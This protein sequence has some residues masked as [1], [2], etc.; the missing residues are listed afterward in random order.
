MDPPW[1]SMNFPWS[2]MELHGVPWNSME[3]HGI[4]WSSMEFHGVPWGY[5]TRVVFID[6]SGLQS[7][8]NVLVFKQIPDQC[9]GRGG[10]G[11]KYEEYVCD[12]CIR[13]TAFEII[14]TI[15]SIN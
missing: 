2:S 15:K 7:L 5:F 4:P 12:I 10:G 6:G 1:D 11:G 8:A 13:I 9:M 3:L 14:M